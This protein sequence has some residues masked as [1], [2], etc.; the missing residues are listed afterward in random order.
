MPDPRRAALH[1]WLRA[2]HGV[3]TRVR[4]SELG[5]GRSSIDH[6]LRTGRLV[7]LWP[8]TYVSADVSPGRL[9]LMTAVCQHYPDAAI[10]F[11]TAAQ[12]WGFREMS[13]PRIHVLVP[14]ARTPEVPGIAF[15][16]C[17]RIDAVDLAGRR[18][19]GVR[20]TSPPRTLFDSAAVCPADAVASA[21]EQALAERRCTIGTLMAT[22]ARLRHPRRP[23]S[24]QF[25]AVLMS[26]DGLRGVARSRL[27]IDVR[28]AVAAAGLPQPFV[29]MPFRLGDGSPI[30]IDLAWPHHRVA[31]EVDHPLWHD[32][33]VASACDRRRDRKLLL[34]GWAPMRITR[35]D[36]EQRLDEAVDDIAEVLILRG[37]RRGAA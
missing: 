7:P 31:V 24:D 8:G 23:G 14:H 30:A 18:A 37:W 13:D 33:E 28:A 16:R 35:L 21:V 25:D 19:D 1:E 4:M 6:E 29:N 10:G 34:L 11:T 2:H 9:Q 12:E 3:I 36:I 26:R 5:F 32:G 20:L 15:H 27:E 22:Q 17:R